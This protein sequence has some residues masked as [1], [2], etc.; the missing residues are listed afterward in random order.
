M[1]GLDVGEL[2]DVI[3][4]NGQ[5]IGAELGRDGGET[6][7]GGCEEREGEENVDMAVFGLVFFEEGSDIFGFKNG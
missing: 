6:G 2:I 5:A 3:D 7:D 1:D 4:H